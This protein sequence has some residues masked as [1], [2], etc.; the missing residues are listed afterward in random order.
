M[1]KKSEAFFIFKNFKVHV[2][3]EV[4]SSIKGLRIDRGG[5][6]TP[7]DFTKFC[8]DNG[9]RRQLTTT[10]TSQQNGIAERKNRTIM[11]M[12]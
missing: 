7:Q 11:N 8:S 6:F 2:E 1:T 12:V 10:Y 9:I 3:K 5:E 4:E